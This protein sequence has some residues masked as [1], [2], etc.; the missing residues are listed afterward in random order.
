M[1]VGVVVREK[2]VVP[3]GRNKKIYGALYEVVWLLRYSV[4]NMGPGMKNFLQ[5]VGEFFF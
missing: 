3:P 1:F 2:V 5:R 4:A